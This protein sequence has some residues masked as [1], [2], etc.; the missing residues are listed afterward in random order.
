MGLFDSGLKSMG[1]GLLV[2]LG[3]AVAAPIILPALAGVARPLAK[4]AIRFY[5][6]LADDIR[7][8][9]ADHHPQRRK[10]PHLVRELLSG[11]TEELV[12]EGLGV[13]A[14]ESVVETVVTVMAEI[15]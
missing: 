1:A 3:T 13:G 10:S 4:A 5:F 14:E 12:T 15:L 9:V 7:E 8:V 6:D 11:G 2:V